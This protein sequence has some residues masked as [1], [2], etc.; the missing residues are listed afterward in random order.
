[1]AETFGTRA[2]LLADLGSA[3]AADAPPQLFFVFRLTGV[4]GFPRRLAEAV[5]NVLIADAARV[6]RGQI[7]PAS[8]YYRPRRD[9]LCGLVPGPL[10]GV[11][12]ALVA[13]LATHNDEHES[14]GLAAGFGAV[15][16]P[17][18]ARSVAGAIQLADRRIAV[19]LPPREPVPRAGSPS[20]RAL[21]APV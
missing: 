18:E 1:M 2:T 4:D 19:L 13:T 11:E 15:L 21:A 5:A 17:R 16:V 12:D 7:G 9:E 3:V 14:S 10:D 20:G 6:L 8:A